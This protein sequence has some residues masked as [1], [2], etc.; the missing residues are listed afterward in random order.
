MKD[1]ES[2]KQDSTP[3]DISR[4]RIKKKLLAQVDADHREEAEDFLKRFKDDT[5]T[6]L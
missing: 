3:I 1:N 4:Q 6:G 2:E 5:L